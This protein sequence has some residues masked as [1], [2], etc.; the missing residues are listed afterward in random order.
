MHSPEKLSDHDVVSGT[1]KVYIPIRRYLGGFFCV[2]STVSFVIL[3][4]PH[5]L[6]FM[7][8]FDNIFMSREVT[9]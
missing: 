1:L 4:L 3:S 2:Y 8:H 9:N 6:F 5:G 7:N